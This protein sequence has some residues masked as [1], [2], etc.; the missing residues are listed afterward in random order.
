MVRVATFNIN[1]YGTR[2]G[3]WEAR[4]ELIAEALRTAQAEIV[5][6]QAVASQPD[7]A[8]GIDQSAQLAELL[9]QYSYRIYQPADRPE[10]GGQQ[11]SAIL[12]QYPILESSWQELTLR[13]GSEDNAYRIVLTV[14]VDAPP[15]PFLL[16]NAHFSW[17]EPQT[18]D[19]VREALAYLAALSGPAMLV[20]DMNAR[21]D[22]RSMQELRNAGWHDAWGELHSD[23]PGF[24][25]FEA[26]QLVQRID[27]VWTNDLLRPRLQAI[28]TIG[29]AQRAEGWR[30]SDHLG[31]VASLE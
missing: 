6:L 23:D 22:S 5:A 19:N 17:V 15:A 16:A 14:Q 7:V 24:T 27:Y 29:Q 8:G 18:I 20:G 25:F 11:G 9:P 4:R 28:G 26:G 30:A 1:G 12:S 10:S 13:G 3:P 31:L 2:H 21:P